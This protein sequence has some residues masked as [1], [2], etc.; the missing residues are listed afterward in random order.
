MVWMDSPYSTT[1]VSKLFPR[2]PPS[3]PIGDLSERV[4]L[5]KRI[6]VHDFQW[7]LD[8]VYPEL[9]APDFDD[10]RHFGAFRAA[11]GCLDNYASN[12]SHGPDLYPCHNEH[13]SQLFLLTGKGKLIFGDTLGTADEKCVVVK[14]GAITMSEEK[15]S[16]GEQNEW[17]YT[18]DRTLQHRS[19]MCLLALA[20][21]VASLGDCDA[22]LDA[23]T[24]YIDA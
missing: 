22:G 8:T 5:R 9:K 16:Q 15:C 17:T 11:K 10:L 1:L 12:P 24:W 14:E 13:G 3:N 19:G 2:L 6:G 21:T 20:S 18:P 4:A 23:R 7:Y